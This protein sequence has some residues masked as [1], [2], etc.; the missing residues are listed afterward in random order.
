MPLVR[1]SRPGR[2]APYS[3]EGLQP[4]LP[5]PQ[6]HVYARP[7][8]LVVN[9]EPSVQQCSAG[10]GL[11]GLGIVSRP[12][13]MHACAMPLAPPQGSAKEAEE[14]GWRKWADRWLTELAPSFAALGASAAKSLEQVLKGKAAGTLRRH[15][16]GWRHWCDFARCYRY[17]LVNPEFVHQ[18]RFLESLAEAKQ[19]AAS[20]MAA[21]RFVAGLLGFD[22]W[23]TM[24]NSPVAVAWCKAGVY[25]RLRK[26]ALPLPLCAV[27]AF[28][29]AV[30]ADFMSGSFNSDTFLLVG[31]L[32]MIWGALRFSDIQRVKVEGLEILPG[33]VRGECWRTKSSVDGMPFGVLTGGV[34]SDWSAA[35]DHVKAHLAGSDFFFQTP[36][37]TCASFSFVLSSLRRL[38]VQKAQVPVDSAWNIVELFLTL[39]ESYGLVLGITTGC[40]FCRS[41]FLG[42]SP[43]PRAAGSYGCKIFQRWCFACL[44]CTATSF[45]CYS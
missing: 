10:D 18:V 36:Q 13:W 37:G 4:G 41:S 44:A 43:L 29:E 33:L 42:A 5:R 25:R 17:S 21:L 3:L 14:Q 8:M 1:P 6:R 28:E 26:E 27:S 31:F 38:L 19:G 7:M 15:L 23:G 22:E 40:W 2:A 35:V 12:S 39:F 32:L 30:L 16:P 34:H 11:L 45:A 9:Q 24:L 20:C